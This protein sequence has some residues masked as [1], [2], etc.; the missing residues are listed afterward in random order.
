MTTF[1]S[2]KQ[3]VDSVS[4]S[5]A[6]INSFGY[7]ELSMDVFPLGEVHFNETGITMIGYVLNNMSFNPPELFGPCFLIAYTYGYYRGKSEFDTELKNNC[8]CFCSLHC[9]AC[10]ILP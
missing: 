9:D 8:Y 5:D 1:E 3:P 7:L 6:E 4:L 2:S 10:S